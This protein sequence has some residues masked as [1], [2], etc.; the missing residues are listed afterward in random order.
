MLVPK[1]YLDHKDLYPKTCG[2]LKNVLML[3]YDNYLNVVE[4]DYLPGKTVGKIMQFSKQMLKDTLT[5]EIYSGIMT[6]DMKLYANDILFAT[7]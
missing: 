7:K 4:D 6:E 2:A 1:H 5:K 3:N